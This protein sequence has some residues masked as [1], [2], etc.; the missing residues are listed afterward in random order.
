MTPTE[1]IILNFEEVRRRSIKLWTAI[2]PENY[3][4]KPDAKAMA[5]L[6]MVRHVLETEHI[7]HTI[8]NGRG[9][10]GSYVS[11]WEDMQYSNLQNEIDFA[12]PFREKFISTV[13]SFS[14][15]DLTSIEIIRLEKGQRRKL[16]DYLL[17]I[18]YHEAVHTGQFLSY[19]RTLGLERP[20]IWD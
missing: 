7:Y 14:A 8:I 2:P 11:P 5:C 18:A 19:L 4:W 20:L 9:N 16:G 13:N 3:F 1:I 6:E 15:E 10:L 12:Q 17:R